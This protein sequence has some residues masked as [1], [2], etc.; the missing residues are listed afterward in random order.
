MGLHWGAIRDAE[1]RCGTLV[2]VDTRPSTSVLTSPLAPRA[3]PGTPARVWT[4]GQGHNDPTT[5]P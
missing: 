3:A 2:S 4:L 1:I 5:T